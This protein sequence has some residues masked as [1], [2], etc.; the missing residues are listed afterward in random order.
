[1]QQAINL[2]NIANF[3]G[4]LALEKGRFARTTVDALKARGHAVVERDRNSG[5]QALQRIPGGW[6]GGADSRSEG[7]VMGE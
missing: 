4:P 5:A 7:V 1:M 6:F 2:P 3:N